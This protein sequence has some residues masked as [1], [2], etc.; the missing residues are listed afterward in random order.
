MV[1]VH[2]LFLEQLLAK[3][4]TEKVSYK[5]FTLHTGMSNGAGFEGTLIRK[6]TWDSMD[7]KASSRGWEKVYC[8]I[9]GNRL[10]FYKDY[11]HNVNNFEYLECLKYLK[12]FTKNWTQENRDPLRAAS[13]LLDNCFAEVATEYTKRR[14][15]FSLR[16]DDG[17]EFLFQARDHASPFWIP[18]PWIL[19]MYICISS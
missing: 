17:A 9:R 10:V 3:F 12:V 13:L 18:P 1:M 4:P 8:V 7:H 11:R 2:D 14:N 6:H 5:C 15:V 19:L 16:L